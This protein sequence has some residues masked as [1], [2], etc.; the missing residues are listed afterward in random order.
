MMC[1]VDAWRS[2]W[3]LV[4]ELALMLFDTKNLKIIGSCSHIEFIGKL[5]VG[6]EKLWSMLYR[7]F[8]AKTLHILFRNFITGL[9]YFFLNIQTFHLILVH[10]S[11]LAFRVELWSGGVICW[12]WVLILS[13]QES[14]R[15]ELTHFSGR[16]RELATGHLCSENLA[17]AMGARVWFGLVARLFFHFDFFNRLGWVCQFSRYLVGKIDFDL[18][19]IWWGIFIISNF[20]L[21][22]D[23]WKLTDIEALIMTN[24]FDNISLGRSRGIL[25]A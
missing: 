20:D 9:F 22:F 1:F 11:Q 16:L 23:D 5:S 25:V 7:P 2:W 21:I 13:I 15:F 6:I 4:S 24:N 14:D 19:D 18:V 12:H 17:V 10:I 3:L 8:W